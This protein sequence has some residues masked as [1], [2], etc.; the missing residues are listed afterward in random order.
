[1]TKAIARAGR[2]KK[3]ATYW[4]TRDLADGIVSDEVRIWVARPRP[5]PLVIGE[6]TAWFSLKVDGTTALYGVWTIE[7]CLAEC[8][9]YP[10]DARMCIRVGPDPVAATPE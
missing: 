7:Q 2:P 10:D 5:C 1:M 3:F 6:G 9:V 4:L 8:R